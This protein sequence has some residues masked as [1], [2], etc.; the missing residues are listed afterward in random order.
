M[1][2]PIPEIAEIVKKY[3]DTVLVVDAI[4][5][6]GVFESPDGR[7]GDRCVDQRFSKGFDAS[8]GAC[9]CGSQR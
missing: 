2:H 7:V 6:I 9:L 4:T 1:K 8:S 5:G 3:E